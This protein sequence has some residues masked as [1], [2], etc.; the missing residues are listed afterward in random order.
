MLNQK[1]PRLSPEQKIA[2]LEAK[3][4]AA[5]EAAKKKKA[6]LSAQ[7]K[8]QKAKLKNAER[9]QDTRCKIIAGALALEHAKH[10]KDF[11]E[12]L[13]RLISEHVDQ[14][15]DKKRILDRL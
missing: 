13:K 14:P 1:K 12:T 11:S 2:E 4:S 3:K 6:Q 10:D 15:E 8:D 7:I 5:D 9:K